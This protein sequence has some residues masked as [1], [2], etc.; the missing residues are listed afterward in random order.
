[1]KAVDGNLATAWSA[2]GREPLD[3]DLG[4]AREFGG[5]VLRWGAEAAS[6]YAIALSDDR[7]I[8]RAADTV[9]GSDGGTDWV[10]LPE[11]QARYLRVQPLAPARCGSLAEVEIKPL[12]FGETANAFVAAVARDH[13][14][15]LFPRGFVGEQSYWTLVATPEGGVSGLMDESGAIESAPGGF[16]VEPFVRDGAQLTT[17]ADITAAQ[18]LGDGYLPMPVVRWQAPDWAL[19]ANSFAAADGNLVAR[20][21]LEN[22]SAEPKTLDLLLAVRPLQVNPPQQFLNITGGVSPIEAIRWDGAALHVGTARVTPATAPDAVQLATFDSGMLPERLDR[23]SLRAI[24]DPSG[25]A[26]G[27]LVYGVRL[28]PGERRRFAL[29]VGKGGPSGITLASAERLEVAAAAEWRRRLGAV[30]LSGPP[31]A[32]PTFATLRSALAQM[33]MSRDG[34][35]LRPGSRAYARSWIRDGAM[36][37][38]GLLRLGET[39]AASDFLEW[40]A[41]FQYP[42]GKVPCCVDPRGADPVPEHD[43]DGEFIHLVAQLHR[44]APDAERSHRMW[45]RVRASAD[46]IEKLRR[47][48]MV[49]ANRAPDRAHFYG[50]L[51][52]SISHEGYSAKPMHSY[53]D[54]FWALGGL[55]DGAWLAAELG[56]PAEADALTRRA[57][58]FEA[59]ILASISRATK[60]H[61]I[62]FIPG[63]ADL[64]DF[65]ATSTTVALSIAGV[66]SI[67]PQDAL[68]TTFQRYWDEVAARHD[69]RKSWDVYTP[70][71]WRNVGAF[72]RLGW[73]ARANDLAEFL[74]KDRRPTEWNQWAEVVGRNP[75]EPRFLGDMPHGWVASDFINATL[76]MLAY[77]RQ[78]D[79]A[80]VLA[81]GVPASWIEAE[82]LSVDRLRTPHGN[83]A[84]T[85]RRVGNR[86]RLTYNLS[87]KP[88]TGGLV[89]AAPADGGERRLNGSR[90]RL[91][92]PFNATAGDS[93]AAEP[94]SS[95]SLQIAPGE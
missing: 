12:E 34:P 68:R 25:L 77:E 19:R 46:H 38:G 28:A 55:R 26:S 50:L 91:D 24:K 85:L 75:R 63:S 27:A 74:M 31:A 29:S 95:N 51:P 22:S 87:G 20:Y 21:E 10:R 62:A 7:R 23:P 84:Y 18:T 47:Q 40:Y 67:L 6:D 60:R 43:S 1:M 59:D 48:T 36:M 41:P 58:A 30:E 71:E 83:L 3:L 52:P 9:R 86:I 39:R 90:G 88:P 53:W 4:Y 45:P 92:F 5:L 69:G 64:G 65:D 2:C 61:G 93:S 66:Q 73:R 57:D 79:D 15:G 33:L 17:W 81:A 80:L 16:S 56:V 76:D 13:R 78:R 44:Y 14:R 89:L 94:G 11:S 32:Q 54:D 49:P 70:Y 82:G 8:W 37:S 72:V 35:A 42:N